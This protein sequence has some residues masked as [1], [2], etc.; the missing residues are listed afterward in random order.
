MN[1]CEFVFKQDVK[2]KKSIGRNAKYMNRTGK[3]GVKMPSDYLSRKEKNALN[4]PVR[5]Y[6]MGKPMTY[7]LFKTMP[8]DLKRAYL[9]GMREKFHP[10]CKPIAK[11]WGIS[12][13]MVRIN[14]KRLGLPTTTGTGGA[15]FDESGWNEWMNTAVGTFDAPVEEPVIVEDTVPVKEV[16]ALEPKAILS[17]REQILRDAETCV[18]GDRQQDYGSPENNFRVIADMWNAYLFSHPW[19]DK[20]KIEPKDV[21]AMLALLKIA[22]IASGNAK[23]DNWVDLAG[24]AACGGEL[25]DYGERTSK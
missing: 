6:D 13:E 21:A 3:G 18:M 24:Y 5:S 20:N 2:E 4:G 14:F 12:E 16:I 15:D 8:E 23:A 1:D 7:A 22:R 19:L 11:M 25:E 10:T 17:K 9:E